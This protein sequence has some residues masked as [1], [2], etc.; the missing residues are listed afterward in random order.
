MVLQ[1]YSRNSSHT[2]PPNE[3]I[4]FVCFFRG[5]GTQGPF[6]LPFLQHFLHLCSYT[7]LLETVVKKM[8]EET[9]T[10]TCGCNADH[11][12]GAVL[13]QLSYQAN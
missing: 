6:S 12:A 7:V 11:N 4:L 2:P 8:P 13:Y 9:G 5:V 10:L 3:K 1:I